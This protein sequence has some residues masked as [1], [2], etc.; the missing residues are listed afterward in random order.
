MFDPD[1]IDHIGVDIDPDGR[2][3]VV[4]TVVGWDTEGKRKRVRLNIANITYI[5]PITKA[6]GDALRDE[7]LL[8]A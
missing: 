7:G 2:E 3:P 5:G 1:R 4:F 6:V 8:P